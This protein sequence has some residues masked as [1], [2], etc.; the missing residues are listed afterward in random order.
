[1]NLIQWQWLVLAVA[2][3]FPVQ[4]LITRVAIRR[5]RHGAVMEMQNQLFGNDSFPQLEFVKGK[6]QKGSPVRAGGM[7]TKSF[8]AMVAT[9]V[10]FALVSWV[11]FMLLLT[12]L[13]QLLGA[14]PKEPGLLQPML[15]WTNAD[16]APAFTQTANVSSFAFLGAYL[17]MMLYLQKAVMNFELQALSFLRA[18][19]MLALGVIVAT[20]AY[21]AFPNLPEYLGGKDLDIQNLWYGVAFVFG[22]SH[23]KALTFVMRKLDLQFRKGEATFSNEI[24]PVEVIDGIDSDIAFRL[25]ENNIYDV[26]NLAT[27]NPIQLCIET[28]YGLMQVFDW[29]LQAQL[30]LVAGQEGHARLRGMGVRTVFDLERAVLSS[31]APDHYVKAIGAALFADPAH[32]ARATAPAPAQ[33]AQPPAQPPAQGAQPPTPPAN[34]NATTKGP[35]DVDALQ[36]EAVRHAVAVLT[37]DLHVHRLRRLWRVLID[38]YAG[39]GPAWLYDVP[40][41]PGD[42]GYRPPEPCPTGVCRNA[43]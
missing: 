32:L 16:K 34:E 29:V 36:L 9:A 12:P 40:S 35:I 30:C 38:K 3:L 13:A 8:S 10:I 7:A 43:A 33:P 37:D 26:Q 4:L 19:V 6:Y 17:A 27:Y 14:G 42:L 18:G 5:E 15:L 28:P 1:M 24:I 25:Q 41:L 22:T 23:E 39:K 20:V 31:G 11:G 2:C 21:R